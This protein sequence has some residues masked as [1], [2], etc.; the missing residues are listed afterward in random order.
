MVFSSLTFLFFF[1]PGT[2]ISYYA[3][4]NRRWRNTLLLFVSLFFYAWGEPVY[5]VLFLASIIVNWGLAMAIA[6]SD[7]RKG[8]LLAACVALNLLSIGVFKYA[9]FVSCRM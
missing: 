3:W 6:R 5:I 4:P 9:G 1:L 7:S 2:L 8:W